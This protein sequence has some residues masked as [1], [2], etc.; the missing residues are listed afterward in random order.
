MPKPILCLDFDGVLHSYVSRWKDA[1]TVLD[2]PTPGALEALA[3][4]LEHFDVQVLSS[5]SHQPG[6]REAMQHWCLKHFGATTHA[7]G[8]PLEKPPALLTLDDRALTFDGTWPSVAT[9]KAFR[10]WNKK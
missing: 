2:D 1:A 4:Y 5:R 8:F 6:G 10:P 3:A 7:L 9:L